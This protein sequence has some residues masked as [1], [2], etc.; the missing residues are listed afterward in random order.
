MKPDAEIVLKRLEMD[1]AD[2]LT[3]G[4]R[5]KI[6]GDIRGASYIF[7]YWDGV[8]EAY[9]TLENEQ[10]L[11]NRDHEAYELGFADGTGD[12]ES[13]ID[14]LGNEEASAY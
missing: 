11:E 3:S 2:L 12:K 8:N 4:Y 9:C 13:I 14:S 5:A 1:T 6:E 7:G 10:E